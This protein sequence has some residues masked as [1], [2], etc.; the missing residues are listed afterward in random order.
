MN[1]W[2]IAGLLSVMLLGCSSKTVTPPAEYLLQT[3]S[4]PVTAFAQS[5]LPVSVIVTPVQVADF[6][7]RPGIVLLGEQGQVY[8]AQHYRWAE[9]LNQQLTRIT[10][11]RL[12][13]RLPN[14]QWL[15][16]SVTGEASA[17]LT[18]MVDNFQGDTAGQWHISGRWQ[19]LAPHGSLLASQPFELSGTLHRDGYPALVQS[20][21]DAWLSQVIDPIARGIA[22]Q[23]IPLNTD[24]APVN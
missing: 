13:Q 22:E 10:L 1:K 7:S 12:E 16:H 4:S 21:N 2:L 9:D 17:Q 5:P 3:G 23:R 19:W 20:L 15:V 18:I 11:Q 8:R 6:L 14:G 24:T